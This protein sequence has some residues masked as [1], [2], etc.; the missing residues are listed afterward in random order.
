MGRD[1]WGF[2][3]VTLVVVRIAQRRA[4]A[5]LD[6]TLWPIDAI[7]RTHDGPRVHTG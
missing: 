6:G 1:S 5:E 4:G 3:V 7:G 2:A